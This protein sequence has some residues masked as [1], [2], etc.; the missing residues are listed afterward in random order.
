MF[1]NFNDNTLME[2]FVPL[3]WNGII[4]D[5][6]LI[7][8]HGRLYDNQNK[9]FV[10]YSIDKD[11]YFMASITVPG[12]GYK[13]IRVHRFELLSFNFIEDFEKLQVNH[14]DG[15]KQ[16][17]YIDNLEWS[18]PLYNTRHGWN[19][20]L[21]QNVENS[22]GNGKYD[23]QYIR[24]ICE[25]ID[26]GLSN[27]Q[28]SDQLNIT[29]KEERMRMSA[30]LAG[31]RKGKTYKHISNEYSFMSGKVK[32]DYGELTIHLLCNLLSDENTYSYKE[33]MDIMQIPNEDRRLFKV[34]IND[35]INKRTG[36]LI[37]DEFYPNLKRPIVKEDDELIS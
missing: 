33:I 30:T 4:V 22:N 25:M 3:N 24:K 10:R 26:K 34:F 21:N 18:T 29:K 13:K 15:N 17:L 9:C 20:G 19:N 1:T 8:D 11:D 35:I 12:Y 6:Y 5:R 23:E 37:T 2:F 14:K 31:I 27:S 16:N 32:K 7:S 36:K 28:I